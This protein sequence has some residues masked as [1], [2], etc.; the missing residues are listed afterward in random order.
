M[1]TAD[2]RRKAA[3]TASTYDQG[4]IKG[5]DDAMTRRLVAST[6]LTESNGGDLA[7][8]NK[9]G[10][11]GRYQGGAS[12]LVEA[13]YVNRDKFDAAFKESGHRSE[14]A[15]AVSGGMTKFL[16]R[17]SNWNN[18]LDLDKYKASGDLQDKAF[19]TNSDKLYDRAVRNGLLDADDSPE[20]VAGYLKASHLGGYGAGRDVL[21]GKSVRFDANGT[22]PYDYYNDI[23]KNRDGLNQLMGRSA[24]NQPRDTSVPAQAAGADGQLKRGEE[25]PEV[26]ALQ[27]RLNKL[28]YGRPNGESLVENGKFGPNTEAAVVKFQKEHGLDGLG[29][30]GP[31]TMAALDAAEKIRTQPQ[32]PQPQQPSDARPTPSRT[33][34]ASHAIYSE[35]YQHFL[36]NGNRYEYGRGDMNRGNKEGNGRT[37]RSR[38]EQDLDGDGLKGV[39]CSSFVWRGLKNAGYGVGNSP[40]TTHALFNGNQITDYSKKNFDVIPAADAKRSNGRMEPGDIILF[41]DKDSGGQHVGIFKGYDSKGNTQFIGSQVSTGPAQ[42]SAGPGSY[43]NG[44]DFE[45]VGALRAKPEFQVRQPV[46]GAPEMPAGPTTRPTTSAKHETAGGD[47]QLKRGEEGPEVTRLQDRL[48]KLGYGRPDGS[49]LVE[50]GKFG[51]NTEA[52]VIKFQKGHGLEGLGVVGPKTLAALD[53]AEKAQ[54]QGQGGQTTKPG[55]ALNA[56]YAM[57]VKHNDVQYDFGSKNLA[58]GKV[59]CSGWVSQLQ[60]ATMNE[61]NQKA[62]KTVFSGKDFFN[63]NTQVAADIIKDSV[64]TTGTLVRSPLSKSQLKEGMIIGEDNGRLGWDKGRYNGIDHITMVVKDPKTGQLMVSQSRSGE[65]VELTTLGKYLERK[66]AKG[67]ELFATDPLAKA[68]PLMETQQTAPTKTADARITA[69]VDHQPS[70]LL[71][72]ASHPDHGLYRQAMTGV[73]QMPAGAFKNAQEREN[74]AAAIASEAKLAGLT[75]IDHVRQAGSGPGIFVVQGALDD[76]THRRI[77]VDQQQVAQQQVQKSSDSVQQAQGMADAQPI[78][79]NRTRAMA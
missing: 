19:K 10:Y 3:A 36:A 22:S 20:K 8:T 67:V 38:T 43:W 17:D 53:A 27:K 5:L 28:D 60:N 54:S 15:W 56:A 74:A 63:K 41:K 7:I 31:K 13:G 76:P 24:P 16:E 55:M 77:S 51:P 46:N 35:A 79:E 11:V 50:N 21:Q 34:P 64:Q 72:N 70:P 59:D 30:V 42:A 66:E 49:P 47:G 68:R 18:G 52:A 26:V 57:S 37:D 25:G 14:W 71:S 75:Q 12:W 6:V 58:S 33:A 73:D 32:Q 40:F 45:I 2:D 78:P 65:G 61:I 9:Q 44:K 48:N 4:N 23:A 29:V 62:G 69:P 39:D 1:T